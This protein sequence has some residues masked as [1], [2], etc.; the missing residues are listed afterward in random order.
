MSAKV[1]NIMNRYATICGLKWGVNH[2]AMSTIYRGTLVPIITYAVHAWLDNTGVKTK[3][4]LIRANRCA[5]IRVTKAYRTASTV[6]LEVL[7]GI[8]L[9]T[10]ELCVEKLR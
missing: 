9:I 8:Q 2:K 5:L 7:A 3:Q 6:A 10:N 4:C 1:K